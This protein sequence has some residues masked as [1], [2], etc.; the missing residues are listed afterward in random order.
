MSWGDF[1]YMY[2]NAIPMTGRDLNSEIFSMVFLITY[3]FI[4]RL[5]C[6]DSLQSYQIN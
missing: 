3:S 2:K 5:G 6:K 4:H 1:S